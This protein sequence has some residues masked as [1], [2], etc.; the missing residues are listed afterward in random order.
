MTCPACDANQWSSRRVLPRL[1]I[2]TCVNCGLLTS[3]IDATTSVSYSDFDDETYDE[4]IGALRRKQSAGVVRF[5]RQHVPRGEWL[6][7]GCGPGYLLAEA[8]AA[9]FRVGGI[10]PDAN[11]VL[12]ARA[13]VGAECIR[14]GVFSEAEA[15]PV[16]VI[17]TLDVLEHIAP[18]ALPGFIEAVRN[19]LRPDGAWIIKVPAAEGLYFRIAHA[20]RLAGPIERLWQAGYAS[21]HLVYFA[22]TTLVRLLKRH[23]LEVVA[24]RY[25]QELPLLSAIPR[26]MMAGTV[27]R[28]LAVLAL[29]AVAAVSVIDALRRK[30]DSLLVIARPR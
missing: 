26:L 22:R 5:V 29:P 14:E 21:P 28:G 24:S 1:A 6:D 7:L 20:F 23:G 8:A 19:S 25:V 9:G 3:E 11:A 15:R 17:S 30:S 10:E 18:A 2:R 4:A 27:S 12:R 13:L 16:D